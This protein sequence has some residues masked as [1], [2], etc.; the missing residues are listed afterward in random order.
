MNFYPENAKKR[1]E[2]TIP[3]IEYV[4]P[5][6]IPSACC[7]TTNAR[8]LINVNGKA[9]RIVLCLVYVAL[10]L[11]NIVCLRNTVFCCTLLLSNPREN[12]VFIA[13]T[14]ELSVIEYNSSLLIKRYNSKC[15]VI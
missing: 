4:K 3:L 6:P 14:G 5:V 10:I 2:F 1:V 7:C 11:K 12:N 15:N 13:M 9:I 8:H